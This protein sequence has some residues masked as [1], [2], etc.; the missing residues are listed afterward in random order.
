MIQFE[1]FTGGALDTNAFLLDAP[2]GKILIDA[3]QGA[4]AHFAN[5]A[6]HTLLLTH[7]HFD[8]T[9]DAEAIRARHG[10]AVHCHPDTLPMI[11]DRD[12]FRTWGFGLE[13]EP[14]AHPQTITATAAASFAGLT[15]RVLE[16]PGHCPGSLCLVEDSGELFGGD[17]LFQ[18][19]V[20]RADLPGGDPELLLSGIRAKILTLPD[21]TRV[22]PG[23]GPQTTVGTERATNPWLQ[24]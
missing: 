7:G 21:A 1:T 4:D 16:V 14:V 13:V 3:P 20:G 6:I 2:A 23:H 18:G 22:L 24:V 11:T 8:H 5:A 10:C 12:F 9:A 15:F 17:V 19:G